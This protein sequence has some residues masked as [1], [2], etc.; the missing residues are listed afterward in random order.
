MIESFEF[1]SHLPIIQFRRR[2]HQALEG[3]N[4]FLQIREDIVNLVKQTIPA[5]HASP[6]LGR[7]EVS[8]GRQGFTESSV[9][10]KPRK[11]KILPQKWNLL[12]L[13][14]IPLLTHSTKYCSVMKKQSFRVFHHRQ[15]SC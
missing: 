12:A 4:I 9:T 14:N 7:R 1:K 10:M 6:I 11:S 5:P 8:Y 2:L 15:V 13:N 3:V